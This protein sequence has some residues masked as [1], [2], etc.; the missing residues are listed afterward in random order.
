MFSV[1]DTNVTPACTRRRWISTS[2]RRLRARRS[3]L[4]T[5]QK[6]TWW[7]AMYSSIRCKSGRSAE[8]A[9]SPASTNSATTRAPNDSALRALASR[10]AG[11]ENPSSRP[12]LDACSLVETR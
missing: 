8:R 11:I 12:P 3:T 10:C 6:L 9:D 5:M 4:C 1:A 2:S 7:V